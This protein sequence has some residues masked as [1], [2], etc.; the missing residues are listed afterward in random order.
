MYK[1]Q[2]ADTLAA[3]NDALLAVPDGFRV[4]RKLSRVLDR[5]RDLFADPGAP[6]VDWAAAEAL[7]FASILADGTPI[8]LTG[9][10]VERGTFSHR[11]ALLRD[12]S[13]GAVY[14]PPVSYT[15]L[16][17]PTSDLV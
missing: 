1:R 8:R 5:R 11:H 7:A 9:E 15:H 3:L 13:S 4:N 16:T 12:E 6:T 14:I 17:L 2:A 10:D